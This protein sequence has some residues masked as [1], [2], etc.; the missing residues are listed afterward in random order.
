MKNFTLLLAVFLGNAVPVA[1]AEE[2]PEKI[3]QEMQFLVGDW[4][5]TATENGEKHPGRYTAQW[6][7]NRTVLLMTFRSD[8]HN[9]TGMGTWDPVTNEIVE[10]WYGTETGR[11][12]TRYK[13]KSDK[14][15]TGTTVLS[16]FDGTSSKG[17]NRVEKT[18]A[19]SFRYTET[20]GDRTMVLEN[21]RIRQ[22]QAPDVST[23]S[24]FVGTW[25]AKLENGGT[26]RWVFTMS[27]EGNFLNNQLTTLDADGKT[28]W[29]MNG[30][31]GV[32][33]DRSALTNWCVSHNGAEMAFYWQKMDGPVWHV[34]NNKNDRSWKFTLENGLLTS[35]SQG[36]VLKF[37]RLK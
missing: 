30:S 7:N 1:T 37:K 9:A 26:R 14:M 8:K 33:K 34:T 20:T 32:H 19:D 4:E 28:A 23:L 29:S 27:P 16:G 2:L 35:V 13:I 6:T 31:I 3:R 5:F 25:E 21:K 15:W 22:Q 24:G 12:E 11:L 36:L 17:T 18:G 10:I